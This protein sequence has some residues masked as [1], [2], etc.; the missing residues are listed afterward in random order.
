MTKQTKYAERLPE[1]FFQRETT[2]VARDLIGKVIAHYLD[3]DWV[4]GSIV[5]TEAYLH[6]D[7]PASHSARGQTPSNASMFDRPGIL[8]V[9]PIHAKHCLNAVTEAKGRGAAVLI[10]AIEPLW[11]IETMQRKRRQQDLRRLTRGPAM[12]CQA[13]AIDRDDDG[14]CLVSDPNLG[15]FE[16]KTAPTTVHSLTMASI[17]PRATVST[18]PPTIVAT[19]R[20][21][22]SKAQRLKLR[23]VDSR[24]RFLSRPMPK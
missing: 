9:Y 10:R 6:S 11:G 16:L 18:G 19:P 4:G 14:R 15:L 21:G 1:S 23:F 17:D 22:I 2:K 7:D 8:Y 13:L 5:E 12:L 20:I 3:G 24:S